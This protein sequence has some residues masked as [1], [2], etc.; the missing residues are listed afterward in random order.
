M[1]EAS[2]NTW[3]KDASTTRRLP[4]RR[5]RSEPAR[6]IAKL[7]M[8]GRS[9][10]PRLKPAASISTR[11][12]TRSGLSAATIAAVAPPMLLPT[13]DARSIPSRS[14]SPRTARGKSSNDRSAG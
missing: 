2:W 11:A 9:D 8:R 6:D 12:S 14:I 4:G 5:A 1:R 13:S 3:R 7:T 10:G